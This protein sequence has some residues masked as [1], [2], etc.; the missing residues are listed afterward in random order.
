MK[1]SNPTAEQKRFWDM[2]VSNIGCVASRMDGF[3]DTRCSIHHIDGRTKPD[4]HWLVLPLSA[5]N[6]QDGTGTPGRIAV[7][8]WKAR[9]ESRYGKQVDLL[10][11]C[12]ERLQDQ[13]LIVPDG[14]LRAVGML[15][16]A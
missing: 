2:L 1:G 3:E 13:G 11:W 7:H 10:I 12:I 9:F 14:A 16:A 15:E 8:P 4:A 6:H 5:G